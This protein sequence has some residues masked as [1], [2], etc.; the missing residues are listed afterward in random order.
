MRA[1]L[2]ITLVLL[3]VAVTACQDAAAPDPTPTAAGNAPAT[4]ARIMPAATASL[5]CENPI[6]AP[7]TPPAPHRTVL[8]TVALDS[9]SVLHVS[10]T[11]PTS[12]QPFFAKTGL[13]IRPGRTAT[14]S[15]PQGQA[16]RVALSWGTNG[17]EWTTSL[18][19]PACPGSPDSWLVFP[20]GVQVD[21]PMCVPVQVR[22]DEQFALVH[23]SIGIPC[24]T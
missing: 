10:G 18:T 14:L 9:Q 24:P 8:D 22:T 5:R 6:G 3:L 1:T 19:I 23:L 21:G 2:G 16:G 15:V 7:R 12:P 4:P 13:M 11:D 17:T 20:G